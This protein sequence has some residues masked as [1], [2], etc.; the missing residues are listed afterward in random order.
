M[1]NGDMNICVLVFEKTFLNSFGNTPR[2]SII[3]SY[4]NSV[5]HFFSFFFF[6]KESIS[7]ASLE[8]LGLRNSS[9]SASQITGTYRHASPYLAMLIFFSFLNI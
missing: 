4:T 6:E 8:L 9:V 7:Q 1:N 5:L 2:S 3:G